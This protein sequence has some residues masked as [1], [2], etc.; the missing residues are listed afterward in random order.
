MFHKYVF[1]GHNYDISIHIHLLWI[2]SYSFQV[3]RQIGNDRLFNVQIEEK[4][5]QKYVLSVSQTVVYIPYNLD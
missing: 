5:E 4:N 2:I 3:G 1:F